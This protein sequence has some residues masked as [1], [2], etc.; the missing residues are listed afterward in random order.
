MKVLSLEKERIKIT[1]QLIGVG[2]DMCVIITGGDKPHIGC[3]TLST[4]RQSLADKNI[5]SATTSVLNLIGHKDDEVARYVSHKLSSALNKNVA[6]SCGIHIDNAEKREIELI[7]KI[8]EELTEMIIN[9]S[10]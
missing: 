2:E 9:E 4:P 10:L 3:V 1:M 6:A 5:I 8:T 7:M